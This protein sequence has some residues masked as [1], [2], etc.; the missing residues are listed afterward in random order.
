MEGLGGEE[1]GEVVEA[2]RGEVEVEGEV[3]GLRAARGG[4]RGYRGSGSAKE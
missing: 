3:E 4:E 1:V 2:G